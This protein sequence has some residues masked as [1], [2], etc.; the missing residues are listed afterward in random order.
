V[1]ENSV[2]VKQPYHHHSTVPNED[3]D[4]DTQGGCGVRRHEFEFEGAHARAGGAHIEF[5]FTIF[6]RQIF[7]L[8]RLFTSVNN[9]RRRCPSL[10]TSSCVLFYSN[11][12]H[13]VSEPPLHHGIPSSAAS[14][15]L[16]PPCLEQRNHPLATIPSSR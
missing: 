2:D 1:P 3:H 9:S 10:T 7:Q 6:R 4:Q 8:H 15:V 14:F 16:C 12:N 11:I 13:I 5:P